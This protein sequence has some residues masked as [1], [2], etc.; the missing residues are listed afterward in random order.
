MWKGNHTVFVWPQKLQESRKR[1]RGVARV[2][3]ELKKL[4]LLA[5]AAEC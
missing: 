2:L 3:K 5:V 1:V 4:F